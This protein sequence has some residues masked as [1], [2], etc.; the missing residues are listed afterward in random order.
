[1]NTATLL[2][3]VARGCG[4][5]FAHLFV[6][7]FASIWKCVI[8]SLIVWLHGSLRRAEGRDKAPVFEDVGVRRRRWLFPDVCAAFTASGPRARSS[9]QGGSRLWI[10]IN[11]WRQNLFFKTP[12]YN[13][14]INDININ[15]IIIII[16][17]III[18]IINNNVVIVVV[19]CF[20]W[21]NR[22][23]YYCCNE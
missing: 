14:H 13:Y 2:S 5:I 11:F 10:L 4:E 17:V 1:M 23:H 15:D 3:L 21:Y 18:I 7:R 16:I 20:C 19:L 6:P 8:F 9:E 22:Y 12:W